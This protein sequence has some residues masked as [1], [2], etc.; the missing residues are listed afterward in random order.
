MKELFLPYELAVIAKE[1]GFN[2]KCLAVIYADGQIVQQLFEK[3]QLGRNEE[4]CIAAPL[5]QQI[6]DWFREKHNIHF[7]I[8]TDDGIEYGMC[9]NII[10]NPEASGYWRY[11]FKS[12]NEAL[13]AAITEAFKLI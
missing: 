10:D 7:Q 13:K 12:Y 2:E 3:L 8:T 1:K 5:Y 4:P 9:L 11:F 6:V